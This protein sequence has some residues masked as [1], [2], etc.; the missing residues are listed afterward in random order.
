MEAFCSETLAIK[1]EYTSQTSNGLQNTSKGMYFRQW[2]PTFSLLSLSHSLLAGSTS[3]HRWLAVK[4]PADAPRVSERKQNATV[5]QWGGFTKLSASI[6][7]AQKTSK[8][9]IELLLC[10]C[11][12]VVPDRRPLC[13][14]AT[15]MP[16]IQTRRRLFHTDSRLGSKQPDVT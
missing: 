6:Q 7:S 14:S 11:Y 8:E 3:C 12:T 5:R 15:F 10:G 1:P 4:M 2:I 16:L 9:C 13:S